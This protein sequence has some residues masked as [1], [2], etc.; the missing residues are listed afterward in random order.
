DEL[1]RR[2]EVARTHLVFAPINE[3]ET[4]PNWPTYTVV[5]EVEIKQYPTYRV[6]V[7]DTNG[8]R[9][10]DN[11][12][13]WTLFSHI[14]ENDIPMTAP[15]EMTREDAGQTMGFLYPDSD[16]G[17]IGTQGDVDV[18][19][20]EPQTVISFGMLGGSRSDGVQGAEKE[21]RNWIAGQ[22]VYVADGPV[23]ILGYNGPAVPRIMS[24]TE[25]QIPIRKR[26]AE[27]ESADET[28]VEDVAP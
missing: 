22:D 18:I 27:T 14:Q 26:D 1:K 15:V 25:V 12:L 16:T 4:P 24:F 11:R 6:A 23:R 9:N 13:F 2:F 19:D 5:G 10:A 28:A 20:V 3:A 8:N 7:A 17:S 21:L